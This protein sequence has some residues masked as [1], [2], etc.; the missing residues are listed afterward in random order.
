[1]KCRTLVVLIA[2]LGLSVFSSSLPLLGQD[3]ETVLLIFGQQF[4]PEIYIA[5]KPL[6]EQAGYSTAV[7]SRSLTALK[8]RNSSLVVSVDLLLEDV[9]VAD[10]PAIV[11]TCDNDVTFGS[12]TQQCNRIIREAIAQE[13][14][15]G[16][17][18]SGPRVL[19]A[20]GV[21]SGRT[22]TGE[23]SQTCGMLRSAGAT[24]TGRAV[25]RDGL[26]ITA[27]DCYCGPA[28]TEKIVE[29]MEEQALAAR[30]ILPGTADRLALA[31]TLEL[32]GVSVSAVSFSS[33][34]RELIALDMKGG[35][36]T[37][38]LSAEAATTL[39]EPLTCGGSVLAEDVYFGG[40][41]AISSDWSLIATSCGQSGF[42]T[43]RD[44]G[45]QELFSFSYG[46]PVY[47]MA[48]SADA[49]YLAV[50]GREGD[51]VVFDVTSRQV[52]ARLA[53]DH[54]YISN[55]AFSPDG[56]M[57]VVAYERP[58]NLL[59][60]WDTTTWQQTSTFTHVRERIDYHDLLFASDGTELAIATSGDPEITFVDP[61]TT[62]VTREFSDHTRGPYQLAFSPNGQLLA[63]AADD[64]T[65]RLWELATGSAVRVI[66]TGNEAG[67][68]AFSPDGTLLAF[69]VWGEG[70]QIW[71]VRP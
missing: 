25:E 57:L 8:A 5:M 22:M 31:A 18:C 33:D 68:V 20:A 11:F 32:P 63:S 53:S 26:L 16:A 67:A 19:V 27:R 66:S 48:L 49:T 43:G 64:G 7:A 2:L 50:G 1:M 29:A 13:K 14:M 59:A 39:L 15:I 6:L 65:V 9:N 69:S 71:A 61:A 10:Y 23:P 38:D 17:I 42:V 12:A 30:V 56:A 70:I 21:V 35:V 36:L 54:E 55:L 47:G 34:S 41:L 58:D 37:W 62:Q 40:T 51:A 45:G 4:R 44:R 3:G 24:C 28:F 46:A 60:T 52:A